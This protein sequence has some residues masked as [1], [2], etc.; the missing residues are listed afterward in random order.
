MNAPAVILPAIQRSGMDCGLCCLQMLIERP[1]DVVRDAALKVAPTLHA[2]GL[3]VSQ[4]RSIAKRLGVTLTRQAPPF[5]EECTGI[6][7]VKLKTRG[8]HYVVLFR[9]VAVINPA[10]GMVWDAETYFQNKGTPVAVLV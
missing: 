8:F 1:Y 2:D 10:D 6:V 4:L 5:P 9:G 7:R 3:W